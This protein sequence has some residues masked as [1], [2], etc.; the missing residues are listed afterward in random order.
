MTTVTTDPFPHLQIRRPLSQAR[1]GAAE[2]T[3]GLLPEPHRLAGRRKL[4]AGDLVDETWK[5]YIY[6]YIY[7]YT[8]FIYLKHMLS[9]VLGVEGQSVAVGIQEY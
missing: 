8:L 2:V 4:R 1:S 3:A 7:I 5:T 6:I 9:D